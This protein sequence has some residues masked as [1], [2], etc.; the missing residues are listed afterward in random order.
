VKRGAAEMLVAAKST[1]AATLLDKISILD[2][3]QSAALRY[4]SGEFAYNHL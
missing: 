3:A 4:G 2:L 1:I